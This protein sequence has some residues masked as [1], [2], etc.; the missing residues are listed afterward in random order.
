M[1][2]RRGEIELLIGGAV[3]TGAVQPQGPLKVQELAHE[4]E[5]RGNVGLLPLDKVVG[6]V[7]GE[8]EPLHQVGNGDRDGA[9]DTGQAVDQD[10]TLLRPRLVW[11]R[12]QQHL[13]SE[14]RRKPG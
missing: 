11:E 5:V 2:G 6:V 4:V 7:E 14:Q 3:V 10:A 8:V 13:W 1:I 12:K 9:A